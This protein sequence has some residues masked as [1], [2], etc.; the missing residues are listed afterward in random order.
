MS[1]KILA[2]IRFLE[3]QDLDLI[4]TPLF[5]I[6]NHNAEK[7]KVLDDEF[8]KFAGLRDLQSYSKNAIAYALYESID[9]NEEFVQAMNKELTQRGSQI[10][11]FLL[12]LW[13]VKD[14]SISLEQVY[15][16]FTIVKMVNWWT[17]RNVFSTC[18]GQFG[19]TSFNKAELW[20]AVDLLLS[21]TRHCV[22]K[23][24]ENQQVKSTTK[25][26]MQSYEFQPG[27]DPDKIENRI[28]R[29]M[30]FLSSARSTAHIPQKI[31]HYMAILECLFSTD[32]NEVIHKVS[33]RTAF[34]LGKTSAERLAI[35]KTVKT[36]YN[37]RSKFV[38]GDKPPK[39]H[40]QL[41]TTAAEVD[42]IIRRVLKKVIFSDYKTFLQKDLTHYFE[43]LIFNQ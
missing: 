14:N 33:E 17:S 1:F 4:E 22:D 13:F 21:Y 28:E 27:V 3:L 26:P 11:T 31:T 9:D 8:M 2:S 20:E 38:H 19:N 7:A 37:I 6:T 29:V 12:F 24:L 10:E 42:N 41:C 40:G 15:G 16:Q 39:T 18:S 36:A 43:G 35:Y 30:S 34:Y 32:G 23:E 25:K 5:R